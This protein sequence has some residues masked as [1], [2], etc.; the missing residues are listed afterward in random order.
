M[1]KPKEVEAKVRATVDRNRNDL[2][3][4]F[5][6]RTFGRMHGYS[7]PPLLVAVVGVL[8]AVSPFLIGL[9]F[10][11]VLRASSAP[12]LSIPL[13]ARTVD[14]AA[15]NGRSFWPCWCHD[16]RQSDRRIWLHCGKSLLGH[17]VVRDLRNDVFDRIMFQ[18]LAS[19]ISI[20]RVNSF[21]VSPAISS[22]SRRPRLK[23]LQNS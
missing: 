11:T 9:I 2:R 22:A 6:G 4:A 20:R 16:N 3:C 10:D 17:A 13:I 7:A 14:V 12:S 8:E 15:L 5:A 19:F 1:H 23:H 18:P 21:P